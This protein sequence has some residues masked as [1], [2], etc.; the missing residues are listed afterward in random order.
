MLI[1]SCKRLF[2]GLVAVV[3]VGS[4][5]GQDAQPTTPPKAPQPSADLAASLEAGATPAAA[6]VEKIMQEAGRNI[7]RRYN[8]NEAQSLETD[9]LMKREVQ[10][11]L[12]EHEGE[13]W[14]VIRDLIAAQLGG[15]P[16]ENREDAMKLGKSAL[17]LIGVAK[18]AIIRA[19]EEWRTYLTPDQRTMHDYDM[20][21]MEKTF[22]QIEKNFSDWAGGQPSDAG[23]F[24]P[25]PPDER[26]P[27][28]PRKPSTG[29]PEPEI[30]TF[31][32]SLFD[33]FVEEFI[34][35]YQLN[36]GQI[37]SARSILKEYKAKASEF[38][39]DNEPELLKIATQQKAALEA[40]DRDKIKAA[41]S[42]LKKAL[43]PI[44][45][46]FTQMEERLK[47]LLTTL[48]LERYAARR[49]AMP[50]LLAPTAGETPK[51]TTE[52]PPPPPAAAPAQTPTEK[53]DGR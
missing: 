29:L 8:L 1:V 3:A 39:K 41:D 17:P 36:Q 2:L 21:E 40:R 13:V 28:R 16:P 32:I 26:S 20:A 4:V 11:F 19:N 34:K 14:P 37:D 12:K 44:Y 33:S 47:G 7:S 38:K 27:A 22:Q 9:K 43:E 18:D 5:Q 45:A 46:L 42:A 31:R 35:D 50:R 48:Q 24:P 15:K 25:P 23:L 49:P 30:E 51:P 52:P 53:K 6:T 10:R